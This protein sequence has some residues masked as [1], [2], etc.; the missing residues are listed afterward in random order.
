M[1]NKDLTTTYTLAAERF[2]KSMGSLLMV[3]P[4]VLG[5]ESL[6]ADHK[7]RVAPI[8]LRQTMQAQDEYDIQ[9]PAGF[10]VDEMPPPVKLDVGFASY[11]SSSV[12][13]DNILH[14]SRTYTV[15]A[16]TLPPEKYGDLQRLARR[17]RSG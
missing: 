2:G 10:T 16:V 17:Y 4:R 3:R 7:P 11:Q 12:L 13:K 1:L 5:S 14:Y 6:E 8:N 9:L 15:R